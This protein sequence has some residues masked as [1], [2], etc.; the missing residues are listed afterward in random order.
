[1]R[2]NRGRDTAPELLLRRE[3]HR[4]GLRYRVNASPVKSL[5]CRP[6]ILFPR[7]KVAVFVDGCFWHSCPEHGTAPQTNTAYWQAKL[8]RNI[9]RD[10]A[11]D[12]ALGQLGWTVVRVWEHESAELAAERVS[13]ALSVTARG[14]KTESAPPRAA[15]Q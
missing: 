9:E 2:G 1:M 11:N 4:R 5:R 7:Q 15:S 13:A 10:R 12:Q 14:E 3:L 8:A 6:D